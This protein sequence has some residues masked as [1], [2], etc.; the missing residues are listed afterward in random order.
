MTTLGEEV[1]PEMMKEKLAQVDPD[2]LTS[3]DERRAFKALMGEIN[4]GHLKI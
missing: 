3:V 4:L 2:K 1:C